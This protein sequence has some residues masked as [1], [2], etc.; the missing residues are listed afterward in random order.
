MSI[1]AVL[2]LAAQ[3]AP[4]PVSPPPVVP[5]APARPAISAIDW[6]ALPP[7]PWRNPPQVTPVLADFVARE[8]VA[9]RCPRRGGDG[10]AIE[11]EVAVMV[12][13]DG[14]VRAVVPRAIG[15]PTVEQFAA[16]LVTSFARNNLRQPSAG[17]Y[18][19]ALTFASGK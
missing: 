4:P 11:V 13:G 12:R 3:T 16:G 7:L 14:A 19:A 6:P 10:A 9:R 8:V 18:R 15:C 17:W 2:A 5:T 1:W